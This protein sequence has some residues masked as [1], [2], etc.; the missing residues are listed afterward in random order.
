MESLKAG[1][2]DRLSKALE[3]ET[4]AIVKQQDATETI[5]T[6][7]KETARRAEP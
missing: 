1:D 4:A 2:Y 7:M 3:D 5:T 6:M